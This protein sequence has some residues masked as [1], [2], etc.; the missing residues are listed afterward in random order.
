[1]LHGRVRHSAALRFLIPLAALL[2]LA[3]CNDGFSGRSA[4]V[5]AAGIL[6]LSDWDFARDGSVPLH[7]EWRFY[8][9]RLI[10]I[11]DSAD[12]AVADGR[13]VPVPAFWQTYANAQQDIRSFGYGTFHLRLILPADRPLL[14]MRVANQGVAYRLLAGDVEIAANGIVG[15]DAATSAGEYRVVYALAPNGDVIDLF[16]QVS[17]FQNYRG[18]FWGTVELGGIPQ[19]NAERLR[20]QSTVLFLIGAIV[21]IGLYHVT[22]FLYRRKDRAAMWFALICA[23]IAVRISLTDERVLQDALP[24]VPFPVF[25]KLEFL[26]FYAAIPVFAVFVEGLFPKAS[27]RS[28]MLL[29]YAVGACSCLGVVAA[30][31]YFITMTL[32]VYQIFTLLTICYGIFV[33][34]RTCVQRDPDGPLFLLGIVVLLSSAAHD[35]VRSHL[36]WLD[37]PFVAPA[38]LFF[39]FFAQSAVLSRR[40]AEAFNS[41]EDLSVNLERKVESRTHDLAVA[42]NT[43]EETSER[44]RILADLARRANESQTIEEIMETLVQTFREQFNADGLSLLTVD[45]GSEHLVLRVGYIRGRRVDVDQLPEVIRLIPLVPESGSYYRTYARKK[46]MRMDRVPAEYLS[47]FPV[48][49]AFVQNS[50]LEWVVELPLIVEDRVIGVLGCFGPSRKRRRFTHRELG[51][52]ERIAAQVAGA[53]R[54]AELLNAAARARAES[55]R[56]LV[57]ILPAAVADELKRNGSVQPQSYELVS[58][59][60]TDFVGFTT[61]SEHMAPNDLVRELDGC[62]TQFDEAAQH[63]GMEKLK[64]IGDAYMCAGG[65]PVTNRTHPVDAG[66][67]TLE[68]QSFVHMATELATAGGRTFFQLRIGIHSGPVT[69]GVIGKNKF[70]YDIWGDTVNTASRMESA[71]APGKINISGAT[72]TL[73]RDFFVCTYRGRLPVKGKGEMDMYFLERIHPQLSADE[74]GRIPNDRFREMRSALEDAALLAG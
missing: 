47:K 37:T 10:T 42:L 40:F 55:D 18:G 29:I 33:G 31:I 65:I 24:F 43:V 15:R 71:G 4:P 57:N 16:M 34:L 23:I 12:A 3:G 11:K 45:A 22:I 38:G 30:P 46:P 1:M 36:P 68:F 53:V 60:F 51:F 48:D 44:T 35:I 7:G 39:F 8:W 6:D 59:L 41:A 21:I 69:A 67:T 62:F 2:F 32:P 5:A 27:H 26:S 73:V 49:A 50:G 70:A 66:L 64:T 63:N 56:L 20:S 9:Q 54:A 74:D 19:L 61:A 17:N 14:N 52:A 13:P 72:Y 28:V 58:V 25:F